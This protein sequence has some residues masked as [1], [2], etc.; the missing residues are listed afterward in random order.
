M[1][2]FGRG[3][4]SGSGSSGSTSARKSKSEI[5]EVD[6]LA[7]FD[8]F[9]DP[10]D[11]D[12][13]NMDGIGSFCELIGIDASTDVRALVLM[14]RLGSGSKPGVVSRTEFLNGM[15][16]MKKDSIEGLRQILPSF[17]PGFL[18][19]NDFRG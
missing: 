13:M 18:D 6:V 1:N 11:P 16:F 5:N 2:I 9:A 4:G 14:W 7:L 8:R 12:V 17:D 10:D 19:R 15:K 3:S